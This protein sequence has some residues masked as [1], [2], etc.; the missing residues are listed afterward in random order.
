MTLLLNIGPVSGAVFE[1]RVSR[2]TVRLR[3]G[4][5]CHLH[6]PGRLRHLLRPG[7]RLLVRQAWRPG[8]RTSCDVVAA[9]DRDILVLE[10]TRLP[11]KLLPAAMR[12]LAPGLSIIAAE[13]MIN[14]TRV[15]YVA[16]APG[17]EIV[18]IE[19]KGTNLARSGVAY[20]P[21]APSRRAVRQLEALAAASRHGVY[22]LIVFTILR[23]DATSLR[24]ER[25]V[26]PLLASRLC[27]LRHQLGYLAYR[28][29]PRLR[30][31]K[32]LVYYVGPVKVEP[33]S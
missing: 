32:L 22:G 20:F 16:R 1:E 12:H 23:P 27:G 18:L 9:W 4:A 13:R 5:L 11:N 14:G 7:V 17:G 15:D 3:G 33:C 30:D 24:P 25:R 21:D 26:D 19:V 8:R 28:V 31:D 29:E 10:D 2:F 6:D